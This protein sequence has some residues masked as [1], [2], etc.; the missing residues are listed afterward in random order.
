VASTPA[1]YP[2][3]GEHQAGIV[4]PVQDR[5]PQEELVGR[6]K[7]TGAPLSGGTEFTPWT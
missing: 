2:F 4:T 3:R 6:T 1:T 5:P 7:G